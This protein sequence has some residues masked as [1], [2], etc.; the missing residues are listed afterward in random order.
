MKFKQTYYLIQ[1]F[2]LNG[3][4]SYASFGLYALTIAPLVTSLF[5]YGEKNYFIGIFGLVI[6]VAEY[7]ALYFKLKMIRIRSELKR[8]AD[9][10]ETGKVISL[11]EISG[12]VSVQFF[13]RLLFRSA[14]IM[15]S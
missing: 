7:F 11:P 15:V 1:N 12:F 5:K 14:I 9:E 6:W 8:L 2:L 3:I 13:F 10:K 4:Y